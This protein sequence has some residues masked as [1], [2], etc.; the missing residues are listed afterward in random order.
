MSTKVRASTL[1]LAAAPLV[2]ICAVECRTTASMIAHPHSA[3][4]VDDAAA[5]GLPPP[6]ITDYFC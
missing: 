4:D 3:A 2:S 5:T 1:Q 6:S